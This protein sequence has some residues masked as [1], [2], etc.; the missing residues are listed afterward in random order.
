MSFFKFLFYLLAAYLLVRLF[1]SFFSEKSKHSTS[2]QTKQHS[3]TQTKA[4]SEKAKF[5]IEADTV[6]YEIIEESKEKN[7]E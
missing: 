7:E 1:R 2:K 4:S 5:N 3:S 6:E